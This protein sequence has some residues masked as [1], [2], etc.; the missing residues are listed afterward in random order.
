MAQG[1]IRQRNPFLLMLQPEA[2]LAAME[3]SEMLDR[4]ARHSCHPLDKPVPP[5]ANA[6]SARAAQFD[7]EDVE[8]GGPL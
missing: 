8:F 2:V 7:D 3:R 6:K 4:L 1:S 5:P